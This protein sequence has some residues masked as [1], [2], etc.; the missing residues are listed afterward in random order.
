MEEED[1][2]LSLWTEKKCDP[3]ELALDE[4]LTLRWGMEEHRIRVCV[5]IYVCVSRDYIYEITQEPV[6]GE[7]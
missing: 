7:H 1:E 4:E 5:C 2:A 3:K 6:G